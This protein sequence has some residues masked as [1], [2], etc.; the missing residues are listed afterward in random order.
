MATIAVVDYQ[1]GNL[2]SMAKALER[3]A[4][5]AS[6]VVTASP[7]EIE[8][9]SRVVFPGVGA[10]SDYMAALERVGLREVVSQAARE[11]PFLGV[12]LGLQALFEWSEEGRTQG[13][14]I[15]KGKVVRFPRNHRSR[16]GERLKVPHM[17]WNQIFPRD[18][19]HP[20]WRGIQP[21][22]WFY[23]VH[24]Y[25]VRPAEEGLVAARCE[26]GFP[27][28]AAVCRANLVAVQFHPE[29]SQDKGLHLLE[30]FVHWSP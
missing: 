15:L 16:R 25:Y 19:A 27:F 8:R 6:I 10:L 18:P 24:S 9:A 4:P 11:K 22:S 1:M 21:G 13:L 20:L 26:Y 30:N 17:G 5:R 12:C 28:P 14:G 23:F 7:R 2:H 29:K 3:V